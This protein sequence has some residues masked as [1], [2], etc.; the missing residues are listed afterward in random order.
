MA[1]TAY[2]KMEIIVVVAGLVFLFG[3]LALVAYSL[4]AAIG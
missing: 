4:I 2:R 3:F 1:R